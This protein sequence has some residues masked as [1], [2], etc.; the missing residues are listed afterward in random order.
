MVTIIFCIV[1]LFAVHK[2][3]VPTPCKSLEDC[4]DRE[5]EVDEIEVE[6]LPVKVNASS[7]VAE[8]GDGFPSRSA[9]WDLPNLICIVVSERQIIYLL[10]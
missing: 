1:L 3:I 5:L 10:F 6:R 9:S 8:L 2:K 7:T 4:K